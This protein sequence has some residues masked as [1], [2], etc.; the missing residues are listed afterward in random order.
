MTSSFFSFSLSLSRLLSSHFSFIFSKRLSLSPFFALSCPPVNRSQPLPLLPSAS[1][2]KSQENAS[3]GSRGTRPRPRPGRPAGDR[4]FE[5]RARGRDAGQGRRHGPARAGEAVVR[6]RGQVGVLQAGRP[7][8][9]RKEIRIAPSIFFGRE[10]RRCL[11][12]F[13]KTESSIAF[14]LAVLARALDSASAAQWKASA[15]RS[16]TASSPKML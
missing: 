14:R 5:R 4:A 3:H 7:C 16:S 6:A 12:F 15:R 13:E 10:R 9:G 1:S 11:F 8:R 2:S